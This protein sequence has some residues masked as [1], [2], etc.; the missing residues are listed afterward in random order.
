MAHMTFEEF[1]EKLREELEE[2]LQKIKEEEERAAMKQWR[3]RRWQL[4]NSLIELNDELDRVGKKLKL[5]DPRLLITDSPLYNNLN[6]T[7][8]SSRGEENG[9]GKKNEENMKKEE[10]M[11][12]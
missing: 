3:R 1:E 9:S 8:S 5:E 11:D 4:K 6:T 12:N 7:S 2:E 10:R